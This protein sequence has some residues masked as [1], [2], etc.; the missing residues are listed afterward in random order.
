MTEED[1]TDAKRL[2]LA[3]WQGFK[4]YAEEHAER[5]RPT[6]PLPGAWMTMAI[7]RTDFALSAVASMWNSAAKNYE[8]Q[9]LRAEFWTAGKA[10]KY[11]YESLLNR[12]DEIEHAFGEKLEWYSEKGVNTC[13]LYLMRE[14]DL[15][16]RDQWPEYH[17]WLTERLDRLH[18][19]LQP[20]VKSLDLRNASVEAPPEDSPQAGA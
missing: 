3:F 8:V 5:I 17:R 1:L 15:Y 19:A 4:S 9:E 2:Q 7:G 11:A 14:A 10:A 20:I 13:R 16:D 12:R 18:R 6:K